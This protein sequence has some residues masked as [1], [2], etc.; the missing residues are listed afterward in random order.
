MEKMFQSKLAQLI[1]SVHL[2]NYFN[3]PKTP[4]KLS[5]ASPGPLVLKGLPMMMQEQRQVYLSSGGPSPIRPVDLDGK[6]WW[7]TAGSHAHWHLEAQVQPRAL[8]GFSQAL[9]W[10]AQAWG[11]GLPWQSKQ[12]AESVTVW[13]EQLEAA[14][15]DKCWHPDAWTGAQSSRHL[16]QK[17]PNSYFTVIRGG[18]VETQG[19]H[20]RSIS[21]GGYHTGTAGL[22]PEALFGNNKC[23]V[24]WGGTS[25]PIP[26][27][28]I[29]NVAL[30]HPLEAL[31]GK[32]TGG[33]AGQGRKAQT[34][35][36]EALRL[37]PAY[38][39]SDPGPGLFFP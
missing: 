19:A 18:E 8:A 11:G 30:Q 28:S 27:L 22:K 15:W 21:H 23:S 38:G 10:Q 29:S 31:N 34:W 5:L 24:P 2:L 36:K 20:H 9:L 33:C 37:G 13:L 32:S 3:L 7:K 26:H 17:T 16:L 14:V 39:H 6:G 1:I 4:S 35:G 12:E 25:S